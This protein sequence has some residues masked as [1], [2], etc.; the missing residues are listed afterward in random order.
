MAGAE[1]SKRKKE[2]WGVPHHHH[3]PPP[4][5]GSVRVWLRLPAKL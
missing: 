2:G 4:P 3:H 5:H 1:L